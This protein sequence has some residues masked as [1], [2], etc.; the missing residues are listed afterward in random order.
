MSGLYF[1]QLHGTLEH[2]DV[3]RYYDLIERE[4][5]FDDKLPFNIDYSA[6]A[7]IERGQYIIFGKMNS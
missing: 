2:W 3:I 6:S 5:V 1:E 4:V 7:G